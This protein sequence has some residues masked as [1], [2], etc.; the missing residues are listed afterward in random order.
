MM[1]QSLKTN[2]GQ[3][4]KAFCIACGL[5][6][7]MHGIGYADLTAADLK[8]KINENGGSGSWIQLGL[9][10]MALIGGAIVAHRSLIGGIGIVVTVWGLI[11]LFNSG[12]I[13]A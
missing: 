8:T 13:G 12:L 10:L 3:W 9:G 2:L 4:L 6:V 1:K 7:L 11:V 5:F